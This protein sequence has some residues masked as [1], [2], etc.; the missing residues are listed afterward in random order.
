L[1]VRG[2]ASEENL[3]QSRHITRGISSLTFQ[4]LGTSALGFVYL[5]V[6]LRLLPNIDYGIYSAV[7]VSV[8]IAS[9]IAPMGLQ[10]AAGKYLS[11]LE[12]DGEEELRSRAK[13]IILLALLM[14]SLVAG[15]FLFFSP[16]LS[17]YFTKS[18]T[19]SQAFVLGGLWLFSSSMGSVLQG[20]VQG[21]KKYASLAGMLFV[22]RATMVALTIIG[23]ELYHN[24]SVAF[25]AWIIYF[26]MLI[27]WSG[28]VLL[29]S[30]P[31]NSHYGP[32]SPD[33]SLGYRKI[34]RYS[35]PLGI[36]GIFFILTSDIDLV[37]VGGDLN[38][39]SLG[40][41][42]TAVTISNV[43]TFVLIGPLITALLPEASSRIRNP[44]NIS[45]GL[46]LAIRFVFLAILPA[47]FLVAALAPQLLELFSGGSKYQAGSEPL[48]IVAT[49]YIFVAIQ[50]V[51]YSTLQA[52]AKTFEVLIISVVAAATIFGLSLLLVPYFGLTGASIARSTS[53]IVGMATACYAARSF[54]NKLDTPR[55]YLKALLSALIPFVLI[56]ILTTFVSSKAWTALP[57]TLI[58]SAIFVT[59]LFSFRV[60]NAEDKSFLYG[61]LPATIR[62][63]LS[64]LSP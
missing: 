53:A 1:T 62:R 23:L 8:G 45:N 34:L 50:I 29:R 41:Y 19:W 4:N 42:N 2:E 56:W 43:L 58:G 57:Y 64:F 7:S 63:R 35:I 3:E 33:S 21:L 16:F 11:D 36:A 37:V 55:F 6:L 60:L 24:I 49:L 25:Y 22:A 28:R 52:T 48:Q 61:A 10:L 12:N 5:A 27:F 31:P 38:P 39:T 13:K 46:R 14:S 59:C 20:T 26:A 47:S 30:L 18:S 17:Q 40:I 51:I 44:S 9:V 54:L 32:K 15:G